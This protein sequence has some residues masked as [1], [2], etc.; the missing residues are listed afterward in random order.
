MEPTG[1]GD[2]AG[3]GEADGKMVPEVLVLLWPGCGAGHCDGEPWTWDQLGEDDEIRFGYPI[4]RR[5]GSSED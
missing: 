2:M 5:E 1:H 3:N 4:G